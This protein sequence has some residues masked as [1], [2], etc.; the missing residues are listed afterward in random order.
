[1][2]HPLADIQILVADDQADVART[3]CNP[4]RRA[5]A[6]LTFVEDGQAA[7]DALAAQ[8]FDLVVIDMKMPPEE[9][10]G[11]WLLKQLH[12]EGSRIPTLVLSGEGATQQIIQAMRLGATDW[13]FKDV[14]DQE[15]LD[16][17]T[18]ILADR[19]KQS[20]TTASEQLPTPIASRLARYIRTTDSEKQLTEGL[21]ALESLLRFA[22][23]VGLSSTPPF[24]L[25]GITLDK[26]AAPAM[27]TWFNVCTALAGGPSASSAFRRLLSCIA[28]DSGARQTVQNFIPIRNGIFHDTADPSPEDL[29]RLDSF[30][31]RVAHRMISS[32]TGELIVAKSM[33][34]DGEMYAVEALNLHGTGNPSPVEILTNIPIV[35]GAVLL[36]DKDAEPIPLSPLM[37][38]AVAEPSGSVHCLQFNGFVRGKGRLGP[39]SVIKFSRVNIAEG[40]GAAS[41]PVVAWPAATAWAGH[42]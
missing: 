5:K 14:A 10:G 29:E 24:V 31:R 6:R 11:L 18:T 28:P 7:R 16:R 41:H 8:P 2:T 17:A 12:A 36:V 30:L 32:R 34:Y 9:W 33:K 4:L 37:V 3:L 42:A 19:H 35:N 25:P 23:V 22:A 40:H 15:L 26:L 20:L 1:M 27:G 13:I 39:A 38:S 21:H